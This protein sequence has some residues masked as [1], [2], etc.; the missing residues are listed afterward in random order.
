MSVTLSV[1]TSFNLATGFFNF[2]D[3]SNYSAQ[4][5]ADTGVK[6]CLSLTGPSGNFYQNAGYANPQ[7]AATPDMTEASASNNNIAL[8]IDASGKVLVGTYTINYKA[9][10]ATGVDAGLTKTFTSTFTYAFVPLPQ[11]VI[12][13]TVDAINAVFISSD[14]TNYVVDTVTPTITRTHTVIEVGNPLRNTITNA[15]PVNTISWP[16]LYNDSY[17]ST[18]TSAL[19]YTFGSYMVTDTIS[20]SATLIVNV[21]SLADVYNGAKACEQRLKS[22]Q[23]ANDTWGITNAQMQFTGLMNYWALLEM[24]LQNQDFT[25]ATYCLTQMMVIGNISAGI[26]SG[27][28]I[29]STPEGDR[30]RTYSATSITIGTG[31]KTFTVGANLSYTPGTTCRAQDATPNP[32][33]FVEGPVSSYSGTTL[34]INVTTTG[35][36]GT[37]ANWNINIGS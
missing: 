13:Q 36:S 4:S 14:N 7:T 18:I 35:G 31:T 26:T 20:G 28:I 24:S 22:A 2:V 12:G 3:T 5:P 34:T 9:Y 10:I 25:E 11:V 15:N 1:T 33:N 21:I 32:A 37:I 16:T 29:P 6:G 27:Q 30:Y 8:P 17:T 23:Q 19:S